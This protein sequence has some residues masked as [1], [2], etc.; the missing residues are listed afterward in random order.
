MLNLKVQENEE[1]V[2]LHCNGDP[3]EMREVA[4]AARPISGRTAERL[5]RG[6]VLRR[7]RASEGF[8]RD[9]AEAQLDALLGGAQTSELAAR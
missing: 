6:E 7:H 2:V 5:T 1:A 4:A 3:A 9:D 8:D